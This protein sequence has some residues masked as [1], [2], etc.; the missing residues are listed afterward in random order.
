MPRPSRSFGRIGRRFATLAML[1]A[2]PALAVAVPLSFAGCGDESVEEF[3]PG[4][5][6]P[7]PD[8]EE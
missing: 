7:E 8:D 4:P 2:L 6:E 5:L 1:L 3:G